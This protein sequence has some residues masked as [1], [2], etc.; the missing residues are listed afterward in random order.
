MNEPLKKNAVSD[1]ADVTRSGIRRRYLLHILAIGS[2]Q[3]S[4]LYTASCYADVRYW[5]A[6]VE[7]IS[8]AYCQAVCLWLC[9]SVCPQHGLCRIDNVRATLQSLQRREPR[10]LPACCYARDVRRSVGLSHPADDVS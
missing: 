9:P 7:A 6:M 10:R 8:D 2:W 3:N 5:L 1:S 4:N